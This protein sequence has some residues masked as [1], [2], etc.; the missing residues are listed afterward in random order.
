KTPIST[1]IGTI[2]T[3]KE[4]EG[5][6]PPLQRMEL[7]TEMEIASTRLNSQVEN[8]LNMS[9]LETGMLRLKRDWCDVN[10]LV[11]MVLNKL[12]LSDTHLML[13]EPD[14][15]LPLFKLDSGLIETALHN[16]IN[17]AVRYT[18]PDSTVCITATYDTH[19]WILVADDG[20]GIPEAERELVFEKFYRLPNSGTGGS[21]LGLSIVK[22]FIEAHGGTVSVINQMDRGAVFTI[23]VPAEVSFL[24]DE[25]E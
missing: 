3:L 4:A 2:D 19:L 10:E 24:K 6:I 16:L 18:P 22:G 12:P 7:L 20:N 1:I 9:R 11:F 25:K 23:M 13:F 21:G 15:S 17:N 8:L 14:D 5:T